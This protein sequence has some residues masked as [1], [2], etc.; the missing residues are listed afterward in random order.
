[1]YTQRKSFHVVNLTMY[2][3]LILNTNVRHLQLNLKTIAVWV[4]KPTCLI[5]CSVVISDLQ[6]RC[7]GA[8]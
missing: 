4:Y 3:L 2:L 1:M 6:F 8:I 5:T 7:I